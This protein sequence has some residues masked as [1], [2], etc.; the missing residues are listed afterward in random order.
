MKVTLPLKHSCENNDVV[1]RWIGGTW[2]RHDVMPS[3]DTC[4]ESLNWIAAEIAFSGYAAFHRETLKTSPIGEKHQHGMIYA[5]HIQM[6]CQVSV[7][8]QMDFHAGAHWNGRRSKSFELNWIGI[9]FIQSFPSDIRFKASR[10]FFF[11]LEPWNGVHCFNKSG[12]TSLTAPTPT[13]RRQLIYSK[14]YQLASMHI[15]HLTWT[16]CE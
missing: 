4:N 13:H 14:P 12:L 2:M 1:I 10:R 9:G 16:T 5:K 6:M 8:M 3:S 11:N 7:N 15:M